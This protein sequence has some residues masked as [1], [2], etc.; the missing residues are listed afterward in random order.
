MGQSLSTPLNSEGCNDQYF[1]TRIRHNCSI[2]HHVLAS[3]IMKDEPVKPPEDTANNENS[4]TSDIQ[5]MHR[6]DDKGFVFVV[7]LIHSFCIITFRNR[8][9][10][11]HSM[12]SKM[13][14]INTSKLY[15]LKS[16]RSNNFHLYT[17]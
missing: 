5:Q 6:L 7:D 4:F 11:F 1:D 15:I 13:C 2:I 9:I 16:I 14:D 8:D 3:T 12:W 10:M 17:C